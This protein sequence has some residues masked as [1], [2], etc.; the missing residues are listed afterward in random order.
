[1]KAKPRSHSCLVTGEKQGLGDSEICNYIG[2][3]GL[4][5]WFSDNTG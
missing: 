1:M 2:Y 3:S 5:K 4:Y